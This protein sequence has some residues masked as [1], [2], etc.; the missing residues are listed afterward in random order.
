MT[1]FI[2][3]ESKFIIFPLCGPLMHTGSFTASAQFFFQIDLTKKI[4]SHWKRNIRQINYLVNKPTITFTNFLPKIIR[5]NFRNFHNAHYGNYG[6]KIYSWNQYRITD[7][8][9][10]HL[11]SWNSGI[12]CSCI[13]IRLISRNIFQARYSEFLVFNTFL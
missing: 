10:S 6:N 11:I 12:N 2:F 1:K 7:I 3:S 4:Y 5:V 13:K 8:L 9:W